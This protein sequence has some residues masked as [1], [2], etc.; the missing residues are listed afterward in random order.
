[1]SFTSLLLFF[2]SLS[3]LAGEPLNIL[4]EAQTR[5]LFRRIDSMKNGTLE[6]SCRKQDALVS[7]SLVK[8]LSCRSLRRENVLL[9]L[10][11]DA[12]SREKALHYP[13]A[14]TGA[15]G[16]CW[17]QALF[18]RRLFYLARFGVKGARVNEDASVDQAKRLA[19]GPENGAWPPGVL[20][21]FD[22][23]DRSLATIDRDHVRVLAGPFEKRLRES[24]IETPI[25][26]QQN[27][28]FF[29][30]SNL[31]LVTDGGSRGRGTN[32][33][34]IEKITGDVAQGRMPL[35]ILRNGALNQH[36]VL[37]KSAK[38]VGD[39]VELTTYDSNSYDEQKLVYR[40]GEFRSSSISG[41]GG[42]GKGD[43]A[44]GVFVKDDEEMDL[45]QDALY[46]HYRDLCRRR[47][48]EPP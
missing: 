8:N 27:L 3:T 6:P 35:L 32:G 28:R 18:Q 43:P 48:A 14:K 25:K 13:A 45:I 31:G 21:P 46:S 37:V 33:A 4:P 23:E 41:M 34:T 40:D 5:D 11:K 20:R 22:V 30:P 19:W 16:T 24:D 12:F 29:N 26:R 36:A 44:L 10:Q 15:L 17:G 39:A 42:A 47:G 2:A 7:D 38:R 1:M 9:N